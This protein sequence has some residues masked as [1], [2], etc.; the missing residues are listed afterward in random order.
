MIVFSNRNNSPFGGLGCLIFGIL[1]LVALFY[2][3]RGLYFLLW[4]AAPVLFAL[5]LILNWRLVAETGKSFIR[6]LQRSPVSGILLALISIFAFP[7]LALYLFLAAVGGRRMAQATG[8]FGTPFDG[9]RRHAKQQPED[10]FVE[11][12]EIES[13]PKNAGKP[14]SPTPKQNTYDD[15]LE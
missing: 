2:I 11:F 8:G 14:D 6:L 12:E 13:K 15:L 4:W 3:L 10:E 7:L 9:G 1:G 5:A